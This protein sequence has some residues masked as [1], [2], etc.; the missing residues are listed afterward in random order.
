MTLHVVHLSFSRLISAAI[1]V[2]A[3]ADYFCNFTAEYLLPFVL[4]MSMSRTFFRNKNKVLVL[5]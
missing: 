4:Q 1:N 5:F 3:T 2:F